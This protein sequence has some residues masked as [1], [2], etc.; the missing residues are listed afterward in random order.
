MLLRRLSGLPSQRLQSFLVGGELSSVGFSTVTLQ[1]THQDGTKPEASLVQ[2]SR[3]PRAQGP[4]NA[5]SAAASG[6]MFWGIG[7]A[8]P[9]TPPW[10]AGPGV[11]KARGQRSSVFLISSLVLPPSCSQWSGSKLERQV[12]EEE[13]GSG[14]VAETVK[15]MVKQHGSHHQER[16]ICG[17]QKSRTIPHL[18]TKLAVSCAPSHLQSRQLNLFPASSF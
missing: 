5:N 6:M 4:F 13:Q 10:I 12:G 3:T 7:R 18:G 1:L 11:Q 8:F 17:P 9:A 16:G 14:L 15:R 2:E